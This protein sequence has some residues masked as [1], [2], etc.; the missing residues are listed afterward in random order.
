MPGTSYRIVMGS[1]TSTTDEAAS[2]ARSWL[3]L[4]LSRVTRCGGESDCEAVAPP[5]CQVSGNIDDRPAAVP[6]RSDSHTTA[7][8]SLG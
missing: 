5:L 1:A 4:A 8:D 3:L 2:S 7:R 6:S